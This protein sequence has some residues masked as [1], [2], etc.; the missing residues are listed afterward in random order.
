MEFVLSPAQRLELFVP[1]SHTVT[2][3]KDEI[4]AQAQLKYAITLDP[5]RGFDLKL[6]GAPFITDGNMK[7]ASLPYVVSCQHRGRTPTFLVLD[8]RSDIAREY[9]NENVTIGAII[10][11]SLGWTL[12]DEEITEFRQSTAKQRYET[13]ISAQRGIL[14]TSVY[15]NVSLNSSVGGNGR[16]DSRNRIQSTLPT[17]LTSIGSKKSSRSLVSPST[18]GNTTTS[19]TESTASKPTGPSKILIKIRFANGTFSTVAVNLLTDSADAV[20][21]RCFNSLLRSKP[22]EAKGKCA[23]DFVLKPIGLATYIHGPMLFSQF[24]PIADA[25]LQRKEMQ[26]DLIDRAAAEE[27]NSDENSANL[28]RPT[29]TLE[30]RLWEYTEVTAT[31]VH[32]KISLDH[33]KDPHVFSVWDLRNSLKLRILGVDNLYVPGTSGFCEINLKVALYEGTTPIGKIRGLL[34]GKYDSNSTWVPVPPPASP[35]P[36]TV[37]FPENKGRIDFSTDSLV[38]QL[39]DLPR[40]TQL[41]FTLSYRTSSSDLEGTPVAWCNMP[42]FGYNHELA[43]GQQRLSM[44]KASRDQ[45]ERLGHVNPRG[46]ARP[47]YMST[48][49]GMP[50]LFVQFDSYALPVVFPTSFGEVE[51]KSS[52]SGKSKE[53]STSSS[54][55]DNS[56]PTSKPKSS[57]HGNLRNSNEKSKKGSQSSQTSQKP[58]FPRFPAANSMTNRESRRISQ[59]VSGY[60]IDVLTP[61]DKHLL[62]KTRELL[63]VGEPRAVSKFLQSIPLNRHARLEAYRIMNLWNV[64]DLDAAAFLELLDAKFADP[65]IRAWA[66]EKLEVLEDE[67]ISD[68]LLQLIQA[69]RYEPY[70]DCA[71]TRFLLRRAVASPNLLGHFFFWYLKS[72]LHNVET[73]ERNGLLLEA[74]LRALTPNQRVQLGLQNQLV[75]ALLDISQK[76]IKASDK[77]N[78]V[79]LLHAELHMLNQTLFNNW[80]LSPPSVSAVINSQTDTLSSASHARQSVSF[81]NFG[82]NRRTISRQNSY[83]A[84]HSPEPPGGAFSMPSTRSTAVSPTLGNGLVSPPEGNSPQE[85][86]DLVS[87]PASPRGGSS[88]LSSPPSGTSPVEPTIQTNGSPQNGALPGDAPTPHHGHTR[89]SSNPGLSRTTSTNFLGVP[90]A[91]GSGGVG[92]FFSGGGP[93]S[94]KLPLNPLIEVSGFITS[95][96]KIMK[97]KKEPLWLCF[98]NADPKSGPYLA[99]FK[100]G[101]DLRQDML[102]LQLFRIMDRLWRSHGLHLDMAIYGVLATGDQCGFVEVVTKSKTIS[103]LQGLSFKDEVLFDFLLESNGGNA[104]VTPQN[105]S[106]PAQPQP[107]AGSTASKASNGSVQSK[108][109]TPPTPAVATIDHPLTLAVSRFTRSCAAYCVATYVLGI[110]DRHNGNVMIRE[111]G[112]LFHIDF[113]HVLGNFKEKFGVRRER[114]PFVFTPEMVYVMGDKNDIFYAQFVQMCTTAY[115]LLRSSAALFMN[116]FAMMMSSGMPELQTIEDLYYLQDTLDLDLTPQQAGEKFS[117]MLESSSKALSTRVNWMIHNIAQRLK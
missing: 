15:D 81:A 40:A 50:N 77:D 29:M 16:S 100:A 30:E 111:D 78:K 84:E 7:L 49:E 25:V 61:T 4:A 76:V 55:R 10:G 109:A 66:V 2:L 92:N 65:I 80:T 45:F 113:G 112:T 64:E 3:I 86:N 19:P 18:N 67:D 93:I 32:T 6:P 115:N 73:F 23:D 106:Q 68:Y 36:A 63:K 82:A 117:A 12:K 42:V 88:T 14:P 52:Q 1:P 98:Q 11:H 57:K 87:P 90:G 104:N 51:E 79:A 27:Q 85:T 48:Q 72:E 13:Y 53:N 96:C 33:A 37:I 99:M 58:L 116:L 107:G 41:C 28:Y 24:K 75:S 54:P 110:G 91:N 101:D 8:K 34:S 70:L 69:L 20:I 21:A 105:T 9:K 56:S 71:L 60:P 47:N 31:Y 97:S 22:E 46:S 62:W 74:F 59:I 102:V 26:V 89:V 44:W 83:Q 108:S 39:A 95:K 103:E 35:N 38:P 94:I 5:Q 114:V 17:M 43:T